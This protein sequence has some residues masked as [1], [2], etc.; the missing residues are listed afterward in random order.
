M[1]R[2][3]APPVDS[4]ASVAVDARGELLPPWILTPQASVATPAI[5]VRK[6][7]DEEWDVDLILGIGE[8]IS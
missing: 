2:R 3:A 7:D 1:L 8:R 4:P 5:S 6:L